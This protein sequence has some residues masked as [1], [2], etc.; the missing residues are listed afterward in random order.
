[1]NISGGQK[2]LVGFARALFS[3]CRVLLL[4][5]PTSS[6]DAN[7]SQFAMNLLHQLKQEK[8]I[9]L[10][11]HETEVA[12]QADKIYRIESGKVEAR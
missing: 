10:I 1:V 5:E 11:T 6:M 12:S 3:D 4:D 9:F 2:Q 8:L 7:M